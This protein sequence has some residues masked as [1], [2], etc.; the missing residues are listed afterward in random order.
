MTNLERLKLEIQQ[1]GFTDE[2]LSI[3]LE[4]SSLSPSDTYGTSS[5]DSKKA[6]YQTALSCLEAIA[7]SPKLMRTFKEDEITVSDF[8]E[9]LQNRI[10][11][12]ERKIRSM[13]INQ[14]ETSNTFML[15]SR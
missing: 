5:N 12:L 15:F 14:S 9:S 3:F 10:D 7:N 2:E 13:T 1:S 4:E 11:Q 8:A 6:I